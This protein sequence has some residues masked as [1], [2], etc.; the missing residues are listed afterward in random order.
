MIFGY[1]GKGPINL[2]LSLHNRNR[3]EGSEEGEKDEKAWICN[4]AQHR[5]DR[6]LSF[7]SSRRNC[8]EL[9]IPTPSP[10]D[11]CASPLWFQGEGTLACERGS[12][13]VPIPTRG[14][15]LWYSRYIQFVLCGAHAVQLSGRQPCRLLS[16][17]DLWNLLFILSDYLTLRQVASSPLQLF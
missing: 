4:R 10:A 7:F 15:T 13:R 11:E 9:G 1:K 6:V 17:V 14:H 3:N 5:V 8:P 2:K 12:G 16:L